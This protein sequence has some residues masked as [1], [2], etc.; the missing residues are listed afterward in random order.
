M[1]VSPFE[2]W[3]DLNHTVLRFKSRYSL[4]MRTPYPDRIGRS[5]PGLR[6]RLGVTIAG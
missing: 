3:S 5:A 4:P 6:R 2:I 1:G